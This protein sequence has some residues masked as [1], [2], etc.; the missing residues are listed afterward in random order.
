[1]AWSLKLVDWGL[2]LVAYS[3]LSLGLEACCLLLA[4]CG[5]LLE[6]RI[7]AHAVN[8]FAS[9]ET[10]NGLIQFITLT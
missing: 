2:K 5:L 7:R 9:V 3:S 10:T 1:M 8:D 6:A 4:A